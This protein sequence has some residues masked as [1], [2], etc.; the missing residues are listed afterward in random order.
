MCECAVAV[1]NALPAVKERVDFVTRGER[2]A[3]VA[4]LIRKLIDN[5]LA[6]LDGR[7]TRHSLLL[8]SRPDGEEV[9]LSPYGHNILIAGPSGSGKSTAAT[10]LLE[11]LIERSYQF[12]IIDAEGDYDGLER[13]VV[14]G[15]QKR[16]P[17]AE[18]VLRIL[19]TTTENVVANLVGLP[20]VDRPQFFLSLLP[21]VEELRA[22]T[23]R[24]HWL[25]VDEAHHM[26]PASWKPGQLVLS[27]DLRRA[28]FI[29][30]HPGQVAPGV[31]TMI[32]S[33]LAVGASPEQTIGAFLAA[34]G[35]SRPALAPVT[36]EPDEV[37]FWS[38]FVPDTPFPIRLVP[39]RLEH[40]RHLRKYAQGELPPDRS[41]Y[42]R[43][44]EGKLNLRA[45]NLILF[46]QLAD[47]VDDDTWTYHLR[48]GDYS[49][50]FRERIKDEELG[51][52]AAGIEQQS[53]L[54]PAESR[55][56]IRDLIER[57]YTLPT[58]PPLPIPGTD[59][60]PKHEQ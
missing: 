5:D 17:T 31:L 33:V 46:M 11:R 53:D 56:A 23:S 18:E 27:G 57:T 14:L 15:D 42:F 43:G 48:R 60:S 16:G 2:G 24:P 35:D 12:C 13:A 26:L 36:L 32:E 45:Q 28:L 58:E 22:R 10:S 29:T 1:A 37:L 38:R 59:A 20:V 39:S 41:F 21:R 4:E 49:Q 55:K 47:G 8:G 50:W 7:L 34:Q 30:V 54:S 6:E 3:G 9:R 19:T 25:V 44:P 52:E 40:H 51:N